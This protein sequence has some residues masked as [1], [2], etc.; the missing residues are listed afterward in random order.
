MSSYKQELK[1]AWIPRGPNQTHPTV[2]AAWWEL[3]GQLSPS[4]SFPLTSVF[5][6]TYLWPPHSM[7]TLISTSCAQ[8]NDLPEATWQDMNSA[9]PPPASCGLLIR[10]RSAGVLVAGL[11]FPTLFPTSHASFPLP[12]ATPIARCWGLRNMYATTQAWTPFWGTFEV[13]GWGSETA[14]R[15][16]NCS[17]S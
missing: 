6:S 14:Q 2:C 16:R 4:L 17:H 12:Q 10:R 8:W 7:Q 9:G 5:L 3:V 13:V 11:S 15:V 1:D